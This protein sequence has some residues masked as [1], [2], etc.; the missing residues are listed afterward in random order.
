[1]LAAMED[2]LDTWPGTLLVVSHDRYLME[3]VTD[4][5]YALVNGTFNHLPGGVDQYL[6]LSAQAASAPSSAA[7]DSSPLGKQDAAAAEI[8]KVSGA[9]ARAA[10]KEINQIDR[11]LS[12]LADQ[13]EALAQK[14]VVHD[15]ADYVGLAKLGAQQQALQDEIEELEMRWMEL[16]DLV[17]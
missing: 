13:K 11:K 12:K 16:S 8:P 5:Q 4:Q 10:Q 3:R 15:Q 1:M 17:S 9:E 7:V 14:M 6:Q 2:L